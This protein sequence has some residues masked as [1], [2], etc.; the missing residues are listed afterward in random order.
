MIRLE[1]DPKEL[2]R[3]SFSY[4]DDGV[5][6]C[7]GDRFSIAEHLKDMP[8]HHAWT[9]TYRKDKSTFALPHIYGKY[10]DYVWISSLEKNGLD[11]FG[12]T[13]YCHAVIS[14]D[15]KRV[16]PNKLPKKR[17][18]C[19]EELQQK[20]EQSERPVRVSKGKRRW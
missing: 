20:F 5:Y 17:R 10:S 4:L 7:C 13:I 3:I 18:K 14:E 12:R 9:L 6:K 1:R 11:R 19:L 16:F 2:F 15:F 8:L